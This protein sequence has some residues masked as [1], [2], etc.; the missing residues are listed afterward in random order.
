MPKGEEVSDV[1]SENRLY[2][3]EVNASNLNVYHN[4]AQAYE[5]EFS[6]ITKKH[7]DLNGLYALDTTVGG[8]VK[9]YLLQTPENAIGF[10]AAS[11]PA[12]GT[13]DIREFY[14]VPTMRGQK[15]GTYLAGQVFTLHPGQWTVKQLENATHATAFWHR[16]LT[17]LGITYEDTLVQDDYWGNVVMQTF[18][19]TPR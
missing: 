11:V 7:P 2:L 3:A 13:R 15:L 17:D 14:V 5:A 19:M 16:A 6:P 18:K 12:E 8:E 10:A 4:L 1:I 9:A